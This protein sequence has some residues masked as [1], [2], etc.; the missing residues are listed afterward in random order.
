MNLS[1]IDVIPLITKQKNNILHL[2]ILML[3]VIIAVNIYKGQVKKIAS[4]NEKKEA[5]Q[6]KNALLQDISRFEKRIDLYKGVI[7][8][9]DVSA[10]INTLSNIAKDSSV[11]IIS[12]RPRPETDY[13]AYI[14]YYFSLSVT[15][16][17]YHTIGKFIGRLENSTD[18][19]IIDNVDMGIL[20]KAGEDRGDKVSVDLMLSTILL[21]G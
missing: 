4:L 17:D 2:A 21:K 19:Y 20:P 1:S 11:R 12:I 16:K 10:I 9:K 18:I 7:N 14:K 3:S 15:A 5:A 8:N 6:R 13:P